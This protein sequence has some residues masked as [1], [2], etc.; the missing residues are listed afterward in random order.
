[1]GCRGGHRHLQAFGLKGTK[2]P[3]DS[4]AQCP[5]LPL[6]RE[7]RAAQRGCKHQAAWGR[8][9]E[10]WGQLGDEEGPSQPQ[11]SGPTVG[12]T[13]ML[14][15]H[16]SCQ[17]QTYSWHGAS[18]PSQLPGTHPGVTYQ[19]PTRPTCRGAFRYGYRCRGQFGVSGAGRCCSPAGCQ[20]SAS[21]SS[22]C[23]LSCPCTFRKALFSSTFMITGGMAGAEERE[24]S[25]MGPDSHG[26]G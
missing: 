25:S 13:R 2:A 8:Q 21:G 24:M 12:P 18:P 15:L 11:T 6:L 22:L 23:P 1:M 10:Q 20:H 26:Q 19:S 14:R 7:E 17:V 3:T 16:L 9:G 5:P 4:W